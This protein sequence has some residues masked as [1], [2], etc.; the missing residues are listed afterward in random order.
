MTSLRKLLRF[1]KPYTL[2]AILAPS[3]MVL[4]VAMDLLQPRLMQRIVDVGIAQYDLS[5][6][7]HSG[8]WMV[9]LA[10]LGIIGGMGCAYYAIHASHGVGADLR[11]ALFYKIQSL[12]F[13][14][15]DTLKTGEL[16]TRITNDVTQIQEVVHI[17]LRVMIRRSYDAGGQ[18]HYG[19]ADQSAPGSA[20]DCAD[21]A[22][23]P[24]AHYNHQIRPADV[25][26]N[27][28]AP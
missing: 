2:P 17:M 3:L 1:L 9:G 27:A 6:V 14:N 4:E 26:G 5:V 12:S 18:P 15:L 11:S 24:G 19:G 7:L 28:A 22:A 8:M 16:V 20:A 13:G 21:A 10:V 23:G 25:L